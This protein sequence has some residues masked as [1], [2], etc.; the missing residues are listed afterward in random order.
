MFFVTSDVVED[1]IQY[2]VRDQLE[3]HPEMDRGELEDKAGKEIRKWVEFAANGDGVTVEVDT[4][5]GT[6]VVI[7]AGEL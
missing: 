4:D 3:E 1:A 6:C 7:P 2:A 5:M